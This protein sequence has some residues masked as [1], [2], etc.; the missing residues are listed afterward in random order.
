[1]LS[2]FNCV[3]QVIFDSPYKVLEVVESRLRKQKFQPSTRLKVALY[4]GSSSEC[5]KMSLSGCQISYC[6]KAVG[7]GNAARE[8]ETQCVVARGSFF[9]HMSLKH[10]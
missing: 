2:T 4:T 3:M 8:P 9:R 5:S 6:L 1:M 10:G 7:D